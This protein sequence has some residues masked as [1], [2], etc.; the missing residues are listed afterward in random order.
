MGL[1]QSAFKVNENVT[2]DRIRSTCQIR[3]NSLI[4]HHQIAMLASDIQKLLGVPIPVVDQ[5][6]RELA[7]R[8]ICENIK[9]TLPTPEKVCM[10]NSKKGNRKSVENL[11]AHYNKYYGANIQLKANPFDPK[12]GSRKLYNLCED[13]YY[14]A[15]TVQRRLSDN[16]QV[17]KKALDDEVRVLE[18]LKAN[19][20]ANFSRE[21]QT[22]NL[23]QT[24]LQERQNE[25][26]A[27]ANE[28]RA[29]S[30]VFKGETEELKN[31][32][33]QVD[34]REKKL[35]EDKKSLGD[36]LSGLFTGA[37]GGSSKKYSTDEM[38]LANAMLNT[39]RL[40]SNIANYSD[41]SYE[42][43]EKSN[44]LLG[45]MLK[46]RENMYMS[47]GSS[48][49][50][51]LGEFEN[52][53]NIHNK[54]F[55]SYDNYAVQNGGGVNHYE[56]LLKDFRDQLSSLE[57]ATM[58]LNVDS[59]M[60]GGKRKR[61]SKKRSKTPKKTSRKTSKRRANRKSKKRTSKK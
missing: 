44:Q 40:V 52:Y 49:E 10:L 58:P 20:D 8:I 45:K 30:D 43:N 33:K 4:N 6:G 3:E 29:L 41:S 51:V 56:S 35:E 22:A 18:D 28:V 53:Q 5:K 7:P 47:G 19:L 57:Y 17:R 37:R 23:S 36:R 9:K 14:V 26:Q 60:N 16:Y 38:A 27:A 15:D 13:L 21:R 12:S 39:A 2:L 48:V 55:D 32:Q 11:V 59:I 1:Q 31:L 50:K 25:M 61:R 46:N 34:V 54:L 42:L 24:Q